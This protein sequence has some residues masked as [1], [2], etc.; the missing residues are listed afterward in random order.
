MLISALISPALFATDPADTAWRNFQHGLGQPALI[1]VN[2]GHS[3]AASECRPI[4]APEPGTIN[5]AKFELGS[6]LFH[7]GRLSSANSIACITCHAGGLIGADRRPVSVGVGGAL[8]TMNAL[9]VFNATFNFR[10]FWDGRA[11]TLEDQALIPIQNE[12]EMANTLD[13]VLQFLRSDSGYTKQFEAVYPDGVTILNM[14]DAI[15]HFQRNKFIRRDTAFQHYLAGDTDALDEQALRGWRR[16]QEIGCAQCHNGINLGG[17]SYQQLGSAIPY[18]GVTREAS[19]NDLGLMARSGREYDRYVFRVPGLH[20]VAITSP[21][22]HD[23]SVATL[24]GAIEQ[25][26]EYQLGRK[27]GSG[28]VQ[29]IAAF[30]KSLG[31]FFNDSPAGIAT[32]PGEMDAQVIGK[33]GVQT[34]LA[35]HEE[36]YLVAITA[37][38]TAAVAL[39]MEMERVHGGQTAHFDF[40]Q[41]QHREL[42]RYAR[43]LNYPPSALAAPARDELVAAAQ[44]LLTTVSRLDWMIA[45]L[46]RAEAMIGVYTALRRAPTND[47]FAEEPGN[48]EEKLAE[49]R[50]LSGRAIK[51]ITSVG[52]RPLAVELRALYPGP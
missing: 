16:F 20:G 46:L 41:F 36:A 43:A 44:G 39:L 22:F 9:S 35:S 6:Q 50:K 28:D 10:Q 4:P 17:N 47:M 32:G 34:S 12:V 27:L 13:S 14:A 19:A 5:K 23:G 30:L 45:D 3:L 1:G 18:Y 8:G 21:Y 48:I 2:A 37:V 26:A 31:G 29:D 15:A 51:D 25:M 42:I 38:E 33:G 52:I 40:L 49:Y 24:E 11:V 7:E